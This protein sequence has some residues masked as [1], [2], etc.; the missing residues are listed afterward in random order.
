MLVMLVAIVT[1]VSAACFYKKRSKFVICIPI[2]IK[3][4][5]GKREGEQN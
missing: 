1:I 2:V 5:A 3:R 4:S